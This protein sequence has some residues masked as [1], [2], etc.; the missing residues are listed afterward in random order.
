MKSNRFRRLCAQLG[1]FITIFSFEGRAAE[2]TP[3]ELSV[4]VEVCRQNGS[5]EEPCEWT[6]TLAYEKLS[7]EFSTK[8]KNHYLQYN[9][10]KGGVLV[11][12]SSN[13]DKR[14]KLEPVA[15]TKA[16]KGSATRSVKE[17]ISLGLRLMHRSSSAIRIAYHME[18]EAVLAWNDVEMSG[19]TFKYPEVEKSNRVGSVLVSRGKVFVL[20]REGFLLRITAK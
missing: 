3:S 9:W 1:L 15:L 17:T 18:S 14:N 2:P 12:E 8:H 4:F 5:I 7:T 13:K 6:T 16:Q 10:P 11:R 20:H 19:T